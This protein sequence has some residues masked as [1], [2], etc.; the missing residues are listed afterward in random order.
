M[1]NRE[2]EEAEWAEKGG[3]LPPRFC[4]SEFSV[5]VSSGEWLELEEGEVVKLLGSDG[6]VRSG[7][8]EDQ[9]VGSRM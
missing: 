7:W 4:E 8:E 3:A 2:R 1:R 5:L 9:D 6:L